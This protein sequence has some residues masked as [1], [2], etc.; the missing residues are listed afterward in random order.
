MPR[1]TI[2]PNDLRAG[3]LVRPARLSLCAAVFLAAAPA[4]P[5][6]A[7]PPAMSAAVAEPL[8]GHSLAAFYAARDG[9][10]LWLGEGTGAATALVDLL[11]SAEADGLNPD[12]YRSKALARAIRSAQGG[13]TAEVRRADLLLS[14][15]FVAYVRDLKRTPP[16][17]IVW[18]DPE[19]KPKPPTPR[20]LLEAAEAAPSLESWVADMR[21]M[22][23][24]YAGLRHALARGQVDSAERRVLR[25]NL[26]RAR[27]LPSGNQRHILVN[28][29]AARLTA[30][31]GGEIVDSMRVVV[32]KPK[33]PT[34]V[35]AA[36]I[37]YTALN[38][39]WYVP[40]D[41]AAERIAPNVLKQGL[42]YLKA[43]GYQVMT[44]WNDDDTIVDPATIDWQAVADGSRQVHIRQLPG[45]AN[46]MGKMKFMFPNDQ[47]VYLHDTPDKELLTEPARMFSGGCVRLEDAPRL[48]AWLHGEPLTANGKK[49]EQRVDLDRPVPVFITYLTVMPSG[50]ELATFPDVYGRDRDELALLGNSLIAG[51]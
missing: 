13:S 15:A 14:Q 47:G 49:A 20:Q 45:R 29:T 3:R 7:A 6:A 5:V 51:R 18:V 35:M 39:Y 24:I 31:E 23:P 28:A 37:R 46:A 32:G 16:V 10:P 4:F 30:Y 41:L 44:N 26:E 33:N 1:R 17:D 9:R 27:A 50:T 19:L 40:P 21:F 8:G 42:G 43:Q 38:P 48:A 36:Y 25:L 22:H 2:A 12:R 11:S 34:P